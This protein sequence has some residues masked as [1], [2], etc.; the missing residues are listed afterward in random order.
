MGQLFTSLVLVKNAVIIH[1]SRNYIYLHVK[2]NI[3]VH[4]YS[5]NSKL[6]TITGSYRNNPVSFDRYYASNLK[7]KILN[8][9]YLI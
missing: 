4:R 7:K 8:S 2:H 1:V 9:I 6:S 3:C 5:T